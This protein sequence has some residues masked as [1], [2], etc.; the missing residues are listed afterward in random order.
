MKHGTRSCYV[1]GCREPQ[2]IEANAVYER[3]RRWEKYQPKP[4][5]KLRDMSDVETAWLAGLLEG[6]G[7]FT[8]RHVP[9]DAHQGPRI[10][11]RVSLQMTDRDV[12]ERVR[13]TV[14]LGSVSPHRRQKE[15]HKDT[16]S[17]CLSAMAAVQE[18]ITILRPHMGARRQEQIDKCLAAIE[19]NGGVPVRTRRHGQTK[20]KIDGCRCDVCYAAKSSANARR[21]DHDQHADVA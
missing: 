14:G 13:A 1:R 11:V 9:A 8:T 2:C 21:R 7:S 12:V 5:P 18:L 4:K 10:R 17:W 19:E 16:Y 3:E 6:E 20:Y 15:H